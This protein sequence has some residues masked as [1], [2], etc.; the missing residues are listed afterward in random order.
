MARR[1]Q[2][3]PAVTSGNSPQVLRALADSVGYITAQ[4]QP[5]ISPLLPGATID[6]VTAKVNEILSRLQGVG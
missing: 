5:I 4:S 2:N 1:F 6:Q 3:I